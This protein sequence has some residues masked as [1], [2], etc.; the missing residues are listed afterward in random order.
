MTD[1]L[2]RCLDDCRDDWIP[3]LD[4]V[5]DIPFGEEFIGRF[6]VVRQVGKGFSGVLLE[7][8]ERSSGKH[9]AIKY[10]SGSGLEATEFVQRFESEAKILRT[11]SHPN[12]LEV[13]DYGFDEMTPYLVEE[14]LDGL[15]L[16]QVIKQRGP[17][18]VGATLSISSQVADALAHAHDRNIVHRDI[19]PANVFLSKTCW[20]TLIDFGLARNLTD[21]ANR[22]TGAG[23]IVGTIYYM[24]PEQIIGEQ[25]TKASDAYALG[26][27]IFTMLTGRLPF[28]ADKSTMLQE[29]VHGTAQSL[30]SA[31]LKE[32]VPTRLVKLV[33]RLLRRAPLKRP[34]NI[35]DAADLLCTL[36]NEYGTP[37]STWKIFD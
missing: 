16:A 28:S 22:I 33:D 23:K 14:L 8:I 1:I 7:A 19:K 2:D 25:A 9:V 30:G 6:Q 29:K 20:A 24:S 15:T 36:C 17:V 18:S 35:R 21:G 12:I 4:H 34:N 37:Q 31:R 26:L 13:Y 10:F 32:K 3:N 27:V 11:L 5:S